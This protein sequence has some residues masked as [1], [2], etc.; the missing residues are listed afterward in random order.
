MKNHAP[1][2]TQIG[3]LVAAAFDVAARYSTDPREVSRLATRV[4]SHMLRHGRRPPPSR[5]N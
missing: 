2:T 1:R 5:H 4:V 3:E